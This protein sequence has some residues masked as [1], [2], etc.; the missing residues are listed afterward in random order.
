MLVV[1]FSHFRDLFQNLLSVCRDI[2]LLAGGFAILACADVAAEAPIVLEE[3]GQPSDLK[4][5]ILGSG[6]PIP[7]RS[8]AGAAILIEAGGETVLIDCGRACGLR[9]SQ[10]DP[11]LFARLSNLLITHLHSDHVVGVPDL[12][13]NG[14]AMGREGSFHVIG[15]AG[16]EAMMRGLVQSYEADT[17]YRTPQGG[18]PAPPAWRATDISG[19][20]LVFDQ[21]GLQITAFSVVHGRGPAFGY[22][23]DYGDH[24]ALIS[25]DTTVAPELIEYGTDVDVAFLE[26]LSPAME[27]QVRSSFAEVKAQQIVGLH[28]TAKQAGEI[29]AELNPKLG[30]YYHT[31]ATC[32]TDPELIDATRNN[33]SGALSVSRDLYSVTISENGVHGVYQ[34]GRDVAC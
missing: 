3:G 6:T 32:E 31:V 34:D 1:F 24:S 30:V 19:A 15:P 9:L 29:F 8:Q 14:H 18:T 27:R 28:L 23:I 11:A 4:I 13:F 22:R 26:V 33:Y 2:T 17:I 21:G 10:Y 7:S 12:L 16:T 20:G 25:G 5:T